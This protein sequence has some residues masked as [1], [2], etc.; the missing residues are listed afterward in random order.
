MDMLRAA[1]AFALLATFIALPSAQDTGQT[2]DPQTRAVIDL[3]SKYVENLRKEFSAIVC[4]ERQTQ[5]LIKPDGRVS[6]RR[7][8]VSDLMFVKVGQDWRHYAFRDVISVDGKPVRDRSDRLRKLFVDNPKTGIEQARAI[9][10]E[11]GRHNLGFNRTGNSPLLPITLLEPRLTSGFNFTL[12]GQTLSYTE[13][14]RP[15]MLASVRSGKRFDLPAHGSLTV[16]LTKGTILSATLTGESPEAPVSM[17]FSV[18]Y[19]E[20]P[21]LKLLVPASMT[22]RYWRTDKPKEDRLEAT[23]TYSAFRR[24]QVTTSEIIK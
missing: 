13:H 7:V 2:A 17:T 10:S 16:D 8:L 21:T 18:K 1:C 22:E 15:T 20:D 4:E 11:S 9:A 19:E 5:T 3:A 24:F 14:R 12:D 6:K 23:M